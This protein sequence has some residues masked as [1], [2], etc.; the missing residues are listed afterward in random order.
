MINKISADYIYEKKNVFGKKKNFDYAADR[1]D[2]MLEITKNLEQPPR[3]ILDIGCGDG[4]LCHVVNK[5]LPKAKVFGIDISEAAIV[6]GRKK[7]KNIN[8]FTAN[9]EIK[10]PFE[11][12]SFDLVISGENIPCIKDTDIYLS[13]IYRVLAKDGYL[14]VTSPN[15]VSWLN[16]ILML[17]GLGPFYYEP[18]F[19]KSIPV[20]K[21][22]SFSMP[23]EKLPPTGLLRIFSPDLLAKLLKSYK[24]KIIKIYGS[25]YLNNKLVKFIDSVFSA[26]PS[27]ATGTII[28]AQK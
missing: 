2:K 27:L 26:F 16:R 17:V 13:E 25:S 15:V 5:N 12:S 1:L 8:L 7:Y 6:D 28:L 4:Y 21:I 18:S 9:A 11:N 23:D 22:G 14:L 24:F 10:L 19:K 20:V 3:R